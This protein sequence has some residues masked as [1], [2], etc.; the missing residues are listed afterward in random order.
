MDECF[1]VWLL[2]ITQRH[3]TE[4]FVFREE[5]VARHQLY[6]YVKDNWSA[7]FPCGPTDL[8]EWD[9]S[10]AVRYYFECTEKESYILVK[11]AILEEPV[12]WNTP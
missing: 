8:S 3:G 5:A 4:F 1:S 6:L 10:D 11:E 2:T 9:E 7:S 12:L